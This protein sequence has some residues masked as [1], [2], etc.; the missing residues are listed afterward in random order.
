[1]LGHKIIAIS[2][3]CFQKFIMSIENDM[4]YKQIVGKMESVLSFMFMSYI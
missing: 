3:A 1:M 4:N 2:A